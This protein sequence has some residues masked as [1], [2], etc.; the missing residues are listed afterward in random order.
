MEAVDFLGFQGFMSPV[1]GK[2]TI[3]FCVLN[4]VSTFPSLTAFQ[5]FDTKISY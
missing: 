1:A 4:H 5:K 2:R 3:Q